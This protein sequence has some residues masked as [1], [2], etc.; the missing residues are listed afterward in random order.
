MKP[1]VEQRIWNYLDGSSS[2]EEQKRI[3]ELI[4]TDP[5]YR[6]AY[7][8]LFEVDKLLT[9]SSMETP[10]MSF[11]RNVMERIKTEPVP[12]SIKA[13]VDKRIINAIAI[14]CLVSISAGLILMLLQVDWQLQPQDNWTVRLPEVQ[15]SVAAKDWITKGFLFLDI[16]IALYG[17]DF[18]LRKKLLKQ[19]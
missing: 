4:Q 5:E 6:D 1:I 7:R 17:V 18:L 8:E 3:E 13:L 10:S 14:F 9:E 15:L 12:G 19:S 11:T 2:P 16:V